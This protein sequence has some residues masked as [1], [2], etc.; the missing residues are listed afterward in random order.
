MVGSAA[1]TAATVTAAAG[2]VVGAMYRPEDEI[3][4][5]V[6]LPPAVPFTVHTTVVLVVP[7]TEAP[8]C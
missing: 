8:N 7:V 4:P 2:G 3:V 5:T 1:L 6:E